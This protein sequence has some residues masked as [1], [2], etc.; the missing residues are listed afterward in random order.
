V[1]RARFELWRDILRDVGFARDYGPS[2][3]QR[4]YEEHQKL[5]RQAIE[6]LW[7]HLDVLSR[8]VPDDLSHIH[9]SIES[10]R[11]PQR[12][13]A[14]GDV[15]LDLSHAMSAIEDLVFGKPVSE[16]IPTGREFE[17]WLTK[18]LPGHEIAWRKPR[19]YLLPEEFPEL[20]PVSPLVERLRARL[21][22]FAQ[23]DEV[24]VG[25]IAW[26]GYE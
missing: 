2:H 11:K 24:Y 3:G 5:S 9:R 26:Y 1:P 14:L 17:D 21:K 4:G 10:A 25:W 15:S 16:E 12:R 8:L 7:P 23:R 19:S 18:H 13:R 22:D 20:P 6:Q